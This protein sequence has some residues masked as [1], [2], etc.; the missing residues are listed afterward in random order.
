MK[1]K[2]IKSFHV[3]VRAPKINFSTDKP[4]I[5]DK[6]LE[7]I[8]NELK[9][10]FYDHKQYKWSIKRCIEYINTYQVS[11]D[12]FVNSFTFSINSYHN[13]SGNFSGYESAIKF[14]FR[15]ENSK[16]FQSKRYSFTGYPLKKDEEIFEFLLHMK[17][18]KS[19]ID[20]SHN[21]WIKYIFENFK[22]GYT[23]DTLRKY[24]YDK[25]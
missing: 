20:V 23:H 3:L 18:A 1:S 4:L 17:N 22:T 11:P 5:K 10:K 16:K 24:Y 19:F 7:E 21:E 8:F 13:L 9:N 6:H 12:H 25:I 15:L 2:S 14:I